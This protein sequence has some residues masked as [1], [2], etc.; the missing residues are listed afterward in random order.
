MLQTSVLRHSPRCL[1]K[2]VMERTTGFETHFAPLGYGNAHT[3]VFLAANK[4]GKNTIPLDISVKMWVRGY[5]EASFDGIYG[6]KLF[7]KP[8]VVELYFYR[9]EV[10]Q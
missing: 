8:R 7:S 10:L 1:Q 5:C 9:G 3:L 6:H 2:L 4:T